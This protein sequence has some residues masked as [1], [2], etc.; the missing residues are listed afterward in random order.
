MADKKAPL[1]TI[2]HR[3]GS[4]KTKQF[5]HLQPLSVYSRMITCDGTDTSS[6][7]SSWTPN[8][9][10]CNIKV[11][12]VNSR[13]SFSCKRQLDDSCL[14]ETYETPPKKKPCRVACHSPDLACVLDS[15]LPEVN[16][17]TSSSSLV[18]E[19]VN[20]VESSQSTE[21]LTPE[22]TSLKSSGSVWLDSS[23]ESDGH[24]SPL[25]SLGDDR[26]SSPPSQNTGDIG[27]AFDFNVDE[28]MCLSPIDYNEKQSYR[29][30]L[31]DFIQSCQTV[32]EGQLSCDYSE[33]CELQS[34][35]K[36][37][38]EQDRGKVKG[39]G[40]KDIEID[41]DE[42]YFTNSYKT[43][44]LK[45]PQNKTPPESEM[46]VMST[47]LDKFRQL[48]KRS[49]LIKKLG[50]VGRCSPVV[51]QEPARTSSPVALCGVLDACNTRSFLEI[52]LLDI[53]ELT[54]GEV[55]SDGNSIQKS[56]VCRSEQRA[57]IVTNAVSHVKKIKDVPSASQQ[58]DPKVQ[59]TFLKE[60]DSTKSVGCKLPLQNKVNLKVDLSTIQGP[61]VKTKPAVKVESAASRQTDRKHRSAGPRKSSR[62]VQ[63]PVV[64][65]REEDWE[66]EKTVYVDS[67]VRHMKDNAEAGDGNFQMA[68]SAHKIPCTIHF[69]SICLV[70][71][72]TELLHLMNTVANQGN[73]RY[74][75]SWQHPSDLSRR[76]Y[77]SR[78][79]GRLFSLDEW[80]N[81]NYRNHRR[82]A[83]VP[84]PFTRSPVL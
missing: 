9:P 36:K 80:Q 70:G 30:G 12:L 52:P 55:G 48:V 63:R 34:S 75:K 13:A 47:P 29:D 35:S 33:V 28:I 44:K 6:N 23:D 40:G 10:F 42:G 65:R 66:R 64:F 22:V 49:P 32:S 16:N 8:S 84:Q 41:S 59:V 37:C 21:E 79:S 57:P 54:E 18:A 68:V 74:G 38:S 73:E 5:P 53:D 43:A 45:K 58:V 71:V 60:T 26:S 2:F 61:K 1:K 24:S 67:V 27:A 17:V 15:T 19:K 7:E 14:D 4:D 39:Q 72:M 78:N 76:N 51:N 56:L 69:D 46:P 83:K 50:K 31:G 81:F 25:L 82:F 20:Y 3:L 62:E 11:E 77:K